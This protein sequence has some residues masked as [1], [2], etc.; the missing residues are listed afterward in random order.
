MQS[1]VYDSEI[2][3]S[4]LSKYWAKTQM[5]IFYKHFVPYCI[6]AVITNIYFT[7]MLK[8]NEASENG[9]A[10]SYQKVALSLAILPLWMY[11][12]LNEIKQIKALKGKYLTS[13][14]NIVDAVTLVLIAQVILMSFE[15]IAIYSPELNKAFASVT[16]SLLT[17]KIF[18]WFRLFEK[19]TFIIILVKQT[20][21]DIG[22]FMVI[23]FFAWLM[24]GFPMVILNQNRY[25]GDEE[26]LL[27]GNITGN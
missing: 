12:A 13:G 11:N 16:S 22:Q 23:I 1:K 19:T 2:L 17:F 7:T 8:D 5:K 27:M 3:K 18:D 25:I 21:I 4:L 15:P 14:W 24:F 9:S 26:S 20:V 6:G 10:T